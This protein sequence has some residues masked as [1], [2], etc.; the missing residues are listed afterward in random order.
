MVAA[1]GTALHLLAPSLPESYANCATAP[2]DLGI[3]K[4]G[5]AQFAPGG[6]LSYTIQ[7]WNY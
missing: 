7:V 2:T 3:K 6:K 1:T 4:T 5:P